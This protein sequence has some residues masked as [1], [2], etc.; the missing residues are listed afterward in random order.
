LKVKETNRYLTQTLI[1]EFKFRT[2]SNFFSN[3]CSSPFENFLE[4]NCC[5]ISIQKKHWC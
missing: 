2:T 4:R 5:C 1:K 3:F